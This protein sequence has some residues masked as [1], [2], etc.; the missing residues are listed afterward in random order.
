MEFPQRLKTPRLLL[1]RLEGSDFEDYLRR[2]GG[3]LF[4]EGHPSL[5]DEPAIRFRAHV[6]H[7]QRHGYGWWAVRD[8][9]TRAYRG[10]GGLESAVLD[11]K[12]TTLV[13]C[14]GWD[15]DYA[16]EL[17]RIAVAQG[18]VGL[19]VQEIVAAIAPPPPAAARV[20]ERA[21]F[22]RE[23]AGAASRDAPAIYRLTARSWCVSP[24]TRDSGR[25]PA[26]IQTV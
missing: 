10:C 25:A 17:V 26:A 7:W 2:C 9:Q 21:G 12:W 24:R 5:H 11:G 20:L 22:I 23:R 16:A 15:R 18:F 3:A 6:D 14:D 19:D 1:A 8:P 13:T 4:S